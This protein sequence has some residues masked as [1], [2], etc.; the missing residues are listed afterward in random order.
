[1]YF[2]YRYKIHPYRQLPFFSTVE[3]VI[4]D[5]V[6]VHNVKQCHYT[7]RAYSFV[8]NQHSKTHRSQVQEFSIVAYKLKLIK[9]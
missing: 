7:Q 6:C 9:L 2:K 1:M 5:V 8:M 4:T 3:N